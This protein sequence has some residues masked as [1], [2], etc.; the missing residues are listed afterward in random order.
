MGLFGQ[1]VKC[2]YNFNGYLLLQIFESG[3]WEGP[4]HIQVSAWCL[5]F[6]EVATTRQSTWLNR[7]PVTRTQSWLQCLRTPQGR[8]DGL[9]RVLTS[10]PA[11]RGVSVLCSLVTQYA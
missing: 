6:P 10:L 3:S 11:K 7:E 2:I 5:I 4:V 1:D 9:S 8:S